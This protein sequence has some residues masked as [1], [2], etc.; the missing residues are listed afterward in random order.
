MSVSG[1]PIQLG[2]T[3]LM[4]LAERAVWWPDRR[5]LLLADVHLGKDQ[6]FRRHGI[7]VPASVLERELDRLGA[8]ITATSATALIILGDWVHAPPEPGE[9]WPER[10]ANWRRG[11]P[12]LSLELIIGN[13]D[14]QL[15]AWLARWDMQAHADAHRIDGLLL[16]HE[17]AA[18]DVGPGLS[19][20]LHPRLQLIRRHQ[21]LRVPAF[22]RHG[23]H[24]VLPAFG[25]FTGGVDYRVCEADCFYVPTGDG[26][27][28]VPG[29]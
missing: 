2:S 11:W 12:E 25:A 10:I 28:T 7:A 1:L 19:G 24:L 8:L 26:V 20:H 4:L 9:Q 21:R 6:V 18:G 16:S 27:R 17:Q 22:V 14:R 15:D 13:H 3:E 29:R 23:D 5:A